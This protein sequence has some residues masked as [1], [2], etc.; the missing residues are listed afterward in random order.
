MDPVS[1]L[2]VAS[3][4]VAFIDFAIGIFRQ[5]HDN[6]GDG[7][8]LNEGNFETVINDLLNWDH[9]LNQENVTETDPDIRALQHLLSEC[10]GTARKLIE[11]LE[12]LKPKVSSSKWDCFH[13][14][15]K[16]HWG[17][18][19]LEDLRLHVEGF[20]SQLSLR[21]LGYIN[22]KLDTRHATQSRHFGAMADR[23][24]Q[25]VDILAMHQR[26][27]TAAAGQERVT[28][29]AV[30]E[31]LAILKSG[32]M[33]RLP[34]HGEVQS[35]MSQARV[36][37]QI[38]P[39][40]ST[41]VMSMG[42]GVTSS[43]GEHKAGNKSF[44]KLR[45]NIMGSLHFPQI[46]HRFESVKSSHR[47]TLDWVFGDEMDH[48]DEVTTPNRSNFAAWLRS[49]SGCYWLRGKAGSGKSTLM[50][51]LY[52][53]ER[54]TSHLLKWS[55]R[56]RLIIPGFFLWYLGTSLQKSQ[57]GLIRALLYSIF[58]QWPPLIMDLMP[59]VFVPY[60]REGV[61]SQDEPAI[62][63]LWIWF[64]KLRE[65][66]SQVSFCIFIDG[67]DEYVGDH[68]AMAEVFL[69]MVNTCPFIKFVVSSRPINSCVD[70]FQ[71]SPTLRL[72]NLNRTD[73]RTYTEDKLGP[74]IDIYRRGSCTELTEEI[75]IKSNG[76][77]LWVHLVVRSLLQGLRDGDTISELAS[78]LHDLPSDLEQLYVHML[79]RIPTA[80]QTQASL[81]FHLLL[82]RD[83]VLDRLLGERLQR[84]TALQFSFAIDD[85]DDDRQMKLGTLSTLMQAQRVA[86]TDAR[87]RS[88]CFGLVE[89]V[90]RDRSGAP[91]AHPDVPSFFDNQDPIFHSVEYMH[92]TAFEFLAQPY[93]EAK[94]RSLLGGQAFD[95]LRQLFRSCVALARASTPMVVLEGDI[96][97]VTLWGRLLEGLLYAKEAEDNGRPTNMADLKL[98]D[99]AYSWQWENSERYY[100]RMQDTWV[101]SRTAG[102]W[103]RRIPELRHRK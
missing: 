7:Q 80:Y 56:R 86:F 70:A 20:R 38:G 66:R 41:Y 49:G 102:H 31:A 60:A 53:D 15:L 54:T 76:V 28:Q 63:T 73:I 13:A 11:A 62:D 6:C 92:H 91:I 37:F 9:D 24:S 48:S 21:M 33:T 10:N 8:R 46:H 30:I 26:Q 16:M 43:T 96:G 65:V 51:Y 79:D 4:A 78:R 89:V 98:L 32:E 52:Q 34:V 85:D 83:Q 67:L 69:E 94:L 3:A 71:D 57:A 35:D 1:A 75:V 99:A 84:L 61:V 68:S 88:R 22:A 72:E 14:A 25:I 5:I 100:T 74:K 81:I 12:K 36:G 40:S 90:Y 82:T 103:F 45:Q 2:G 87:V 27:L 19:Q 29:T 47:K 17:A 44:E 58:Q 23:N 93:V 59:E 42:D 18:K 97:D 77:F 95:P 64:R 50:K 55:E 39:G 101:S